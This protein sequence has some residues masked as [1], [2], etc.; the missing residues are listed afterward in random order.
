MTAAVETER[1]G[2]SGNKEIN[3]PVLRVYEQERGMRVEGWMEEKRGAGGRSG[4]EKREKDD[5]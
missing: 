4:A 3:R 2:T 1:G 5:G